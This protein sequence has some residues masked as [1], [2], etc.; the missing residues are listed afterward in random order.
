MVYLEGGGGEANL[1]PITH[2]LMATERK[3]LLHQLT[4]ST[5]IT[6][7]E[8]VTRL[9]DRLLLKLHMEKRPGDLVTLVP[10]RGLTV[11]PPNRDEPLE[12][13][14]AAWTVLAHILKQPEYGYASVS[15]DKE[16]ECMR[17][18]WP[19]APAMA[20]PAPTRATLPVPVPVAAPA[21]IT[22]SCQYKTARDLSPRCRNPAIYRSRAHHHPVTFCE[23]HRCQHCKPAVHK[24]MNGAE[25]CSA[26]AAKTKKPA[27]QPR[28][29]ESSSDAETEA[30]PDLIAVR[31]EL[32][33][34]EQCTYHFKG[35]AVCQNPGEYMAF[36]GNRAAFCDE[37][38]C[39]EC[40]DGIPRKCANT[41]AKC[42][43]CQH[44][45]HK[46][47]LDEEAQD[48]IVMPDDARPAK[49]ARVEQ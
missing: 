4:A 36:T 25:M 22:G 33:P 5:V 35:G 3:P 19:Q 46:R 32:R 48:A 11:K 41:A 9:A 29:A 37:H 17:F 10:V 13:P 8:T 12:D 18:E 1:V 43:R 20:A 38:R 39:L 44:P 30:M 6:V 16:T 42:S 14:S 7:Q 45:R 49:R 47:K 24:R 28:E 31:R 40:T 34:I 27:E 21:A 26:C 23:E 2:S 15:Y